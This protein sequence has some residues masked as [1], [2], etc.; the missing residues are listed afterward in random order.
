M[1]FSLRLVLTIFVLAALVCIIVL[2]F[3]NRSVPADTTEIPQQGETPAGFEAYVNA[4]N[5]GFTKEF[6]S[7]ISKFGDDPATGGRSAGSPAETETAAL[8]EQT[9]K[10]IGLKNVTSDKATVDG[11]TFRGASL[12]F[13]GADGEMKNV[14]LGGYQTN[15]IAKDEDVAVIDLNKGTAADY[16]GV[17]VKG[18]L[19]LID[20]DQK[21]EWWINFPAYQAYIKGARAV[22]AA[23]HMDEDI[24]DRL[25]S[26]DICGPSFAP[27]LAISIDDAAAIRAAIENRAEP[28]RQID[29][30][31]NASSIVTPGATT[32]NVWGEIP[33]KTDDVIYFISHYDGYYHSFFDDAVGVGLII[34]MAKAFIDSGYE[35]EK[36]LRFVAHGAEEWGKTDSEADWSAGAYQQIVKLHPEWAENAFALINVD[37][38]YPLDAM[39]SFKISVPYEL[40]AFAE[41]T[42][43]SYGDRSALPITADGGLPST[44]RE[45]FIYNAAGVPTFAN[46]GVEGDEQYFDSLYHSNMDTLEM[47]GYNEDAVKVI[48]RFYGFIAYKL[49]QLP[50]RPLDFSSRFEALK[51]LVEEKR[52][53]GLPLDPH[54]I[55]N[56]GRAITAADKLDAFIL[57]Q[58]ASYAEALKTGDEANLQ[59]IRDAAAKVNPEMQKLYREIQDEFLRLD[60]RFTYEFAGEGIVNTIDSLNTA[61]E[62][63]EAGS[64]EAALEA[65]YEID[66][67][68]GASVFDKETCDYFFERFE[69]SLK[70]TWAEGRLAGKPCYADDVVRSLLR[71]TSIPAGDTGAEA[72]TGTPAAVAGAGSETG[73]EADTG[74]PAAVADAGDGAGEAS[75]AGTGA[76][77]GAG[78]ASA[79][80]AGAGEEAETG[81]PVA[82]AGAGD[83]AGE[84]SSAVTGEEEQGDYSKEI[85]ALKKLLKEQHD[86]MLEVYHD[87]SESLA[88]VTDDFYALLDVYDVENVSE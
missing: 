15:I 75:A 7:Q 46:E 8:I 20:I 84:A 83:G 72:E 40:Q 76:E 61:I 77:D 12:S 34:S 37:S 52:P 24:G 70:D 81:T 31:F 67:V 19:V 6:A 87:Q 71:K 14:T 68:F 42:I 51:T 60:R 88:K 10:D 35:P 43:S 16:E 1:R 64:P 45:D 4:G 73:A 30:R 9:M 44:D 82:V 41:Q 79:A 80:V 58:N 63:L 22:L 78:E 17:D 65:L 29:V 3:S 21:N 27:A 36:T 32:N 74:T 49:D 23:T 33:G 69:P 50:L 54:L 57:K 13:I 56:T 5:V 11:W 39:R 55:A 2:V 59:R 85:A 48:A 66:I 18:K 26:Q 62:T 25:V 28:V 53:E 47:G 38:G 86:A